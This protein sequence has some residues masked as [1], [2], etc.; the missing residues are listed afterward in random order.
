MR[1]CYFGAYNPTYSRNRVL[2][3][4]LRENGIEVLECNDRSQGLKKFWRL[5]QK[6]F[7]LPQQPD[8]IIAGF[9]GQASAI[10]AKIFFRQPLILDA[11]T[12]LYDSM[13]SDRGQFS[14]WS[15]RAG[16]YFVL[17]FLALHLAD[18][19]LADTEANKKFLVKK[20]KI[21]PD[22]VT[23]IYVGADIEQEILAKNTSHE[24]RDELHCFFY[25]TFI[26]L[27][28]ADVIVRS[29]ALLKDENIYFT[30][31]G[32]GQT[33]EATKSLAKK[34]NVSRIEFMPFCPYNELLS[35][36]GQS[37]VALGVFGSSEKSL[38]V[39]PNKV[40]DA[41]ALGVP[42]IT[43][44]SPALREVARDGQ[45][46]FLVKQHDAADLARKILQLKNN[47][48]LRQEVGRKGKELFLAR[49]TPAFAVRPLVQLMKTIFLHD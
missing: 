22:K 24:D 1:V 16:W 2:V 46:C 14:K 41:W 40:F 12:S 47:A 45:E 49:F 19:V 28:G 17:D 21:R 18:F 44:D 48:E 15:V 23:V 3:R 4:G 30:F 26:P 6:F 27:Q 8:V 29:A 33:W 9:P 13:V 20:F 36:L 7:A 32:A 10:W 39:I 31:L 34:L 35:Q 38:R 43:Q 25:G 5:R 42:C 11:L 37:D